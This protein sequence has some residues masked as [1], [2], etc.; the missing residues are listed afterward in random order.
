MIFR[1]NRTC[2][3]A[4]EVELE[5][6]TIKNVTFVGGCSGS[7][8]GIAQLVRGMKASDVIERL[9]G[10]D[11]QGRGTSCP[12]QLARALRRALEETQVSA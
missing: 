3:R 8:K 10:T 12:D 6:D 5:K 4:I 2:S 11:C 9:E 1:T 7:T